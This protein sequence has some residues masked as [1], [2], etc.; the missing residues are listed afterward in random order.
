[1]DESQ[2]TGIFAPVTLRV[3]P[4]EPNERGSLTIAELIDGYMAGYSGR[5]VTR[6]ARLSFWAMALG[7]VRLRDLDGDMIADALEQLADMPVRR[8]MGR[9]PDGTPRLRTFGRR[10]PATL[11]R[12]RAALGAALT[13]AR[14]RRLT[15]KG[16]QSPL[17]EITAQPEARGRERFLSDDEISRLLAACRV[18]TWARLRLLVLLAVTTGARRG[19]LLALRF[20]DIDLQ[21]RTAAVRVSK[22]GDSRLLP[23]TEAAVAELC[24]LGVGDPQRLLFESSKKTGQPFS[25]ETA[26]HRALRDAGLANSGVVFHSLRHTAASILARNGASLIQIGDLLGHRSAT[27]TRRYAHLCIDGRR[28][29]VDAVFGGV[30]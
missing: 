23:L 27:V 2:T 30:K 13:W 21:Q 15:P 6:A 19:E 8:Y 9:E 24:R 7:Q 14:R 4:R 29:M 10:T 11:N 5:D 3:Q 22:N 25:I 12:F 18:S 1:M 16:W 20:G 28:E 17:V 26:W